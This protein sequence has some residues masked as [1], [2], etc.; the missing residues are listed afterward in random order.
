MAEKIYDVAIVGSP[1]DCWTLALLLAKQLNMLNPRIVVI[2]FA[3]GVNEAVIVSASPSIRRFHQLLGIS[4]KELVRRSIARPLLGI[5]ISAEEPAR[6]FFHSYGS[7]LAGSAEVDW[8]IMAS[9]LAYGDFHQAEL[10]LAATMAR[11]GK[12]IDPE[13]VPH[14]IYQSLGVGLQLHLASYVDLLRERALA[15]GVTECRA[16]TVTPAGDSS[17]T[18][19]DFLRL[20]QQRD[21]AAKL[22]I[23]LSSAGLSRDDSESLTSVNITCR[24][25]NGI[26]N[27]GGA[28]AH[29]RVRGRRFFSR[30]HIE[31]TFCMR[32][33][34]FQ[35]EGTQTQNNDNNFAI[36]N[37][38]E[39]CLDLSG[40]K[41]EQKSKFDFN[42]T[43]R[44]QGNYV[45]I[46]PAVNVPWDMISGYGEAARQ[47]M[48]HLLDCY[49]CSA[50]MS[51]ASEEFNRLSLITT[52]EHQQLIVIFLLLTAALTS[53]QVQALVEPAIYED[54]V[55]SI[56]LFKSG[57]V[58]SNYLSPLLTRDQ[59]INLFI[60]FGVAPMTGGL[61][62]DSIPLEKIA[63]L[64]AQRQ[65]QVK[66]ASDRSPSLDEYIN[67]FLRN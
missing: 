5:D 23:D 42:D 40:V 41:T 26:E 62:F 17:A 46:P 63:S 12:F 29:M 64:A 22:F 24:Q 27:G 18:H 13:R 55:H 33:Y 11:A 9:L 10:S 43:A 66:S 38:R 15:L 56:N 8:S 21:V 7:S 30:T 31:S 3:E 1:S 47:N 28:L 14:D 20:D 19:I 59:W 51:G 25:Y 61:C 16:Q 45:R 50:A 39:L 57:A 2:S 60:G 65:T 54:A 48:M 44:W 58:I 4:A 6:Y 49:A 37:V 34:A 35:Q 53:S 32:L 36:N 67:Y 52:R